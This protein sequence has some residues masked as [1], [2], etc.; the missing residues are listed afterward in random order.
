MGMGS[1]GGCAHDAIQGSHNRT[2]RAEIELE[3][4][5]VIQ[6]AEGMVRNNSEKEHNTGN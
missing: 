4:N 3:C 2:N 6:H 5:F 1:G